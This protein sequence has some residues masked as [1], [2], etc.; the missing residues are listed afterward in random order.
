MSNKPNFYLY[1]GLNSH[2]QVQIRRKFSW[3][4][5]GITP[6]DI[7]S[8]V[9][10]VFEVSRDDIISLTRVHEIHRA[11]T[12]A[13]ALMKQFTPLTYEEISRAVGRTNHATAFHNIH[14]SKNWLLSYAEYKTYYDIAYDCCLSKQNKYEQATHNLQISI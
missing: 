7:I 10:D 8:I 14:Q 4:N 6:E 3:S 2:A 1:P 11:R 12:A 5:Q 9:S 13:Q